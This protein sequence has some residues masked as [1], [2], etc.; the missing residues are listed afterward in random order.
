LKAAATGAQQDRLDSLIAKD[1][2]AGSE[3]MA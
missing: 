2:E 3:Q 1:F